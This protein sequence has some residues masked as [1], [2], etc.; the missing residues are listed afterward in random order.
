MF[1]SESDLHKSWVDHHAKGKG[2]QNVL[3]AGYH[4]HHRS[5]FPSYFHLI[6]LTHTVSSLPLFGLPLNVIPE[7]VCTLWISCSSWPLLTLYFLLW[8]KLC[9]YLC[10]HMENAAA[11][12]Q[13]LKI[14]TGNS[15]SDPHSSSTFHRKA[16]ASTTPHCSCLFQVPL[17]TVW[18][19]IERN[20]PHT[21]M[22]LLLC[23]F[24]DDK[25]VT[26]IDQL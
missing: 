20:N 14:L 10:S 9:P 24:L 16:G 8:L 23:V 26:W 6:A 5:H 13:R 19:N 12:A 1:L 7:S 18:C 3:R 2:V 21:A 22:F 25:A 4:C 17:E 15:P 11:V